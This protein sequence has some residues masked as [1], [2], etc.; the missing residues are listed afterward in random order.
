M[1]FEITTYATVGENGHIEVDVPEDAVVEKPKR[2]LVGS[3]KGELLHM[4]DDFDEPL[5]EFKGYH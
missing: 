1:G 4:N 3:L 5:S 2:G